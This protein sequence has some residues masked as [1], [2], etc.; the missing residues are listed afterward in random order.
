MENK[1]KKEVAQRVIEKFILLSERNQG[2][3]EGRM[4]EILRRK[5]P[6]PTSPTGKKS[7]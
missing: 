5:N 1:D 4:D 7:A 2:Y 6:D 3:I